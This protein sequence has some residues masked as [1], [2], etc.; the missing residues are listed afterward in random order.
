MSASVTSRRTRGF[1]KTI[2][3]RVRA[4][5]VSLSFRT[6]SQTR[7]LRLTNCNEFIRDLPATAAIKMATVA[8]RR[9]VC[10]Q[11]DAIFNARTARRR[12]PGCCSDGRPAKDLHTFASTKP[13]PDCAGRSV[14][15]AS[16]EPEDDS[17]MVL[18]RELAMRNLRPCGAVN[19]HWQAPLEQQCQQQ[20]QQAQRRTQP[21]V[22][23]A[24]L[25]TTARVGTEA[26]VHTTAAVDRAYFRDSFERLSTP[27]PETNEPT[28]HFPAT[29][30]PADTATEYHDRSRANRR[31]TC[32]WHYDSG[33]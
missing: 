15:A 29:E 26:C 16:D 2:W 5:E 7:R 6:T 4:R 32:V 9:G 23:G 30:R 18:S 11:R 13:V 1:T 31:K 10:A 24:G 17:R 12:D 14:T 27:G 33:S 21:S 8:T 22:H 20:Q 25:T 28:E 3:D 19:H